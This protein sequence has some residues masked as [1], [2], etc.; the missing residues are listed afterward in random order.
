MHVPT[1]VYPGHSYPLGASWMG[2]GVNFAVYSESATLVTLCLFDEHGHEVNNINLRWNDEGVRHCFLPEARPGLRYGY[3]A[4]GVFAPA[5][6]LYFNPKKLLLDPY[7]KAVDGCLGCRDELFGYKK[8]SRTGGN[9]RNRDDFTRSF[10]SGRR[11]DPLDS[12]ARDSAPYMLK[13]VVVD[14]T[15]FCWEGDKPLQIP[16]NETVIYEMHVKGFS[17]LNER[18]P[19]P[20]RG[21]YKGLAHPASVSYLKELGITA[22]ELL[23]VH[24]SVSEGRL[25]DMG[26]SNYWGYNSLGFFC[27]DPRFSSDSDVVNEFKFMVK[28]L[29]RNGL[30]VILDVVYNHTAEQGN[31]GPQLCYRGLDNSNYYRLEPQCCHIYHNFTGCGNSINTTAPRTLQ[32]IMDS[33]RYWVGEM[34]VDGFRFDLATT[35]ARS[36]FNNEYNR[37]SGF[38]SAVAQD[39]LLGRTKLIAEP[40]DC[41]PGGYQVGGFPKGWSEWNGDW[42]DVVRRFWRGDGG[43]LGKLASKLSG[44]SDLYWDRSPLA[45]INFVTAHDGFTLNDLVTYHQKR[46]MQ[47]GECNR[48]GTNDNNNWNCGVEGPTSNPAVVALRQRQ[49]RNMLLTVLLSQGIPMILGGDEIARTQNGNNNAYC[50]DNNISY[51]NWDISPGQKE[52]FNFTKLIIELRKKHPVFK[53]TTFFDGQENAGSMKDVIW[54][55]PSG[56]EMQGCDWDNP[57]GGS[58]GM[59]IAGDCLAD[60]DSL[61]ATLKDSS[62]LLLFNNSMHS[63]NFKLPRFNNWA[64]WRVSV[65]T[66]SY[67]QVPAVQGGCYTMAPH[68]AV[69]LEECP[70]RS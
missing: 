35:L 38:L 16:L 14:D 18:I 1:V 57:S 11:T 2:N 22:V 69:V 37:Y 40:W 67:P 70:R 24:L 31:D 47:N 28:E 7:A 54:L 63:V 58:L 15:Q 32:L 41:G 49:M 33:L 55:S 56:S 29:H 23:P 39:P 66:N 27:P 52:L 6:G 65:D 3:R 61:G 19:A 12:D 42:R 20:L 44:S 36:G 9:G 48:D 25:T 68:S 30:E 64:E 45:S 50:Q 46:N 62:F 60:T 43:L 59:Y 10:D 17:K 21:T 51:Y 53:R 34:H 13:S 4:Q 26:L 8:Y 5:R